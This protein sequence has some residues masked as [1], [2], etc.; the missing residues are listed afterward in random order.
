L[1]S[2]CRKLEKLLVL[3]YCLSQIIEPLSFFGRVIG[4]IFVKKICFCLFGVVL[5]FENIDI[6]NIFYYFSL[7]LSIFGAKHYKHIGSFCYLCLP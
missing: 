7:F 4:Q 5:G 1:F 3:Q 6:L 2:V